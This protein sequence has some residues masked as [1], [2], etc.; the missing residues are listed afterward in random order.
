MLRAQKT[1]A[2]INQRRRGGG[3]NTPNISSSETLLSRM[4]FPSI[5]LLHFR[6]VTKLNYDIYVEIFLTAIA[7]RRAVSFRLRITQE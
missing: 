1:L 5:F 7:E 3:E 2:M 4:L 6:A